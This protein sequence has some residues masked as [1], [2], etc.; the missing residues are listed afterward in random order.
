MRIYYY[1]RIYIFRHRF[2]EFRYSRTEGSTAQPMSVLFP[3]SQLW[4]R[5]YVTSVNDTKPPTKPF[6]RIVVY[7]LPNI[8]SLM[9]DTGNWP[10]L[11]TAYEKAFTSNRTCIFPIPS[12]LKNLTGAQSEVQ[13]KEVIDAKC[14]NAEECFE[15]G[16]AGT[17]G[18]GLNT[19]ISLGIEAMDG[20]GVPSATGIVSDDLLKASN[21]FEDECT[22]GC[23][24]NIS[25]TVNFQGVSVQEVDTLFLAL[26][27]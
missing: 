26:F 16:Q 21:G 19:S 7:Y 23:G 4:G 3:G 24:T 17:T 27:K 22:S 6:H 12:L 9:P 2:L 8:W 25:K 10:S 1:N 14:L 5:S 18:T 15:S 11:K 20:S 13:S